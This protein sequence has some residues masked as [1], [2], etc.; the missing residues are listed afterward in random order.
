MVNDPVPVFFMVISTVPDKVTLP[1]LTVPFSGT[2]SVSFSMVITGFGS[3]P[4]A[5]MVKVK[6][7][8]VV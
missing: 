4:S 1:I 6:S 5:V 2:S 8:P 3:V 7:P